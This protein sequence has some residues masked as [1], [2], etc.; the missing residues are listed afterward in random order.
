MNS[1]IKSKV[2]EKTIKIGRRDVPLNDCL[3]TKVTATGAAS[4]VPI[5]RKAL[6]ERNDLTA[7]EAKRAHRLVCSHLKQ[8][9]AGVFA[10]LSANADFVGLGFKQNAKGN[11]IS[12][13]LEHRV[14]EAE[15]VKRV[16]KL[17]EDNAMLKENNEA[18]AAKLEAMEKM[19][20][21]A[22]LLKD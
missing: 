2:S 15:Q 22:G 7:S 10:S 20:R 16:C 4:L 11:R 3:Q 21:D 5:S 6:R 19:L 9:Q 18:L 12:F 8:V 14:E 17:A 13:E 1:I